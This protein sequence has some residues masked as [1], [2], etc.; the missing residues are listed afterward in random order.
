MNRHRTIGLILIAAG[1]L[2]ALVSLLA[3]VIG[4]GAFP[5]AIG[6]KQF[7]G[8]IGGF[9]LTVLGSFVFLARTRRQP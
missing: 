3:D 4:I 6:W 7:L 8:I 5:T 1:L 9:L 2:L